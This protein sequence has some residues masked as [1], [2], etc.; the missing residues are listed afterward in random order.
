MGGLSGAGVSL[1]LAILVFVGVVGV[2][3]TEAMQTALE[4]VEHTHAVRAQM[5]A[6]D[7]ALVSADATRRGFALAGEDTA[8]TIS[9]DCTASTN[10]LALASVLRPFAA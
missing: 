6:L 5:F 1:A 7:E 3:N 2:R 4:W 9:S 8:R 10:S